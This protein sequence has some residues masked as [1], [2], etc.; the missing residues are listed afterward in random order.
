MI[1]GAV[2]AALMV[3]VVIGGVSSSGGRAQATVVGQANA[4]AAYGDAPRIAGAGAALSPSVVAVAATPTGR[5]FWVVG[6]DG[7]VRPF[8]RA[9]ATGR[10]RAGRAPIVAMAP[11]PSGRGYWLAAADGGVFTAGDAQF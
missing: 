4:V 10:T 9:A 7:S 11:T 5:G 3:A 6:A 1:G 2:A 8:G